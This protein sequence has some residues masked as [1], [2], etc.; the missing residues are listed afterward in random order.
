MRAIFECSTF[1][2]G[3]LLAIHNFGVEKVVSNK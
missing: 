3:K 2:A 1:A